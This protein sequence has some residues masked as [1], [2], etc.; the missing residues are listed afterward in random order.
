[1]GTA[2]DMCTNRQDSRKLTI[3][4]GMGQGVIRVARGMNTV[5]S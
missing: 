5:A 3:E 1:M 2:A 4:A